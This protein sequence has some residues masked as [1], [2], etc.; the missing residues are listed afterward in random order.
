MVLGVGLEPTCAG[1]QPAAVTRLA[2]P[3]YLVPGLNRP[4]R[5]YEDR[6]LP[7]GARGMKTFDQHLQEREAQNSYRST[8]LWTPRP[9]LLGM[10]AERTLCSY[11]GLEQDLRNKPCG[12]GG[13]DRTLLLRTPEGSRW[14]KVDAKGSTYGDILR[15]DAAKIKPQT[16]YVNVL[17]HVESNTGECFGWEWGARLMRETPINWCNNGVFVHTLPRERLR[18]MEE[19]KIRLE[20]AEGFEPT[21]C[22]IQSPVP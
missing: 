20:G 1:P 8:R 12:D 15:V 3:A 6:L 18:N 13:S 7:H 14:F 10:I 9:H 11:F 22:R 17:V 19:L 16:I 21:K 2:Y 5:P 4:H